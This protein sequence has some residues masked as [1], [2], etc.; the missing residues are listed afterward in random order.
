MTLERPA[1]TPG[2]SVISIALPAVVAVAILGGAFLAVAGHTLDSSV[3]TEFLAVWALVSLVGTVLSGLEWEASR[4]AA[5]RRKESGEADLDVSLPRTSAFLTVSLLASAGATLAMAVLSIWLVPSILHGSWSAAVFLL[6][7]VAGIPFQVT[8]RGI[9]AGRGRVGA[10]S[11]ILIGEVLVRLAL[12]PLLLLSHASIVAWIAVL[13][14]GSWAWVLVAP[15]ELF[16]KSSRTGAPGVG[17]VASKFGILLVGSI[18]YA[19][20]LMAYPALLAAIDSD[21]HPRFVAAMGSAIVMSRLPALL[22][23]PLLPLLVAFFVRRGDRRAAS[24]A[25]ILALVAGMVTAVLL[26]MALGPHLLGVVFGEQ[27][28]LSGLTFGVLLLTCLLLV[29]SSVLSSDLV[30]RGL[31]LVSSVCWLTGAATTGVALA[32]SEADVRILY[33]GALL[34]GSVLSFVLMSLGLLLGL[35]SH[36]RS[37]TIS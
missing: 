19:S 20:M 3:F 8:T 37:P 7:G 1:E 21:Q 17:L 36:V 23:L 9:L 27:Y 30:A 34:L 13:A 26:G 16:D 33:P 18:G 14:V 35:G 11:A 29:L 32:V 6:I 2:A 25:T 12:V 10:Y 22:V 31:H 5:K 28:T 15:T 4:T 24:R